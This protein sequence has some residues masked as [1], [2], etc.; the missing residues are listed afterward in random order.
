MSRRRRFTLVTGLLVGVL[1]LLSHQLLW[2]KLFAYSPVKPGFTR[3]ELEHTVVYV[4]DGS[5][6]GGYREVDSLIPIVER[7][8]GLRF[9]R[10]PEVIVFQ[11]SDTY[12]Q[13][14]T[15]KA[16]YYTYPRGGIVVSPWAV[17]EAQAGQIS[18]EV[19][20]KHELSH[21]LLYQHMQLLNALFVFP[22]WLLDGVATYS[23]GQMGTSWYPSRAET[24]ESIQRGNF[25]PPEL[26]GTQAED[27]VHLDVEH[28]S[29]F[30]YSQ[31]ACMV[32]YL[33]EEYG[34]DSFDRYLAGLLGGARHDAVFGD[35]YGVDFGVFVS[36]FK[37]HVSERTQDASVGM[38]P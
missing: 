9:E 14:T 25:M 16:R 10:K 30:A 13:R 19:Y 37:Q 33:I 2:G 27:Q 4:Q 11:D 35:V 26:F 29:P 3:H 18:M 22:R 31:F 1:M 6:F 17:Q 34:R 15:T 5:A 23:S 8:H 28:R 7:S 12:S 36:D 24:Y 21:A 32:D 38:A 20:L